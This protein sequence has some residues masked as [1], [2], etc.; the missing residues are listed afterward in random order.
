MAPA[1]PRPEIGGRDVVGDDARGR[2]SED[3]RLGDCPRAGADVAEGVHA[4]ESGPE[5]GLVDRH[6]AVDRQARRGE[7]LGRSVHRD[8]DEQVIGQ[9]FAAGELRRAGR[10]GRCR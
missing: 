5:V 8:A 6:P 9:R 2:L 4:G 3:P 10:S 1:G 7:R